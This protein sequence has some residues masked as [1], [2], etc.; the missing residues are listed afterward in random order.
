MRS[1]PGWRIK[2]NGTQVCIDMNGM[3]EREMKIME[4]SEMNIIRKNSKLNMEVLRKYLRFLFLDRL[5]DECWKK[6]TIKEG[7]FW[8]WTYLNN[9]SIILELLISCWLFR[10]VRFLKMSF[11]I[12]AD[13]NILSNFGPLGAKCKGWGLFNRTTLNLFF[14]QF[15]YIF[16]CLFVS[17]KPISVW[18]L[19]YPLV[20]K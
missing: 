7:L 10:I 12:S 14:N 6:R 16:V 2:E 9:K 15:T 17:G 5:W 8:N 3:F 1:N 19:D 4:G 18:I 13:S 11:F 20:P